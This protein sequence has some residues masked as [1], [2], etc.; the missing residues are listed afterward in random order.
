VRPDLPQE[1]IPGTARWPHVD[2]PDRVAA[3]ILEWW[4]REGTRP[5]TGEE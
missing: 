4:A 3:A 1:V 5:E 2:D